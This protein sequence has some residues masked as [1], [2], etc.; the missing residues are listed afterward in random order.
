MR[1][2]VFTEKGK[3]ELLD[4]D[5]SDK[6]YAHTGDTI[7]TLVSTGTELARFSRDIE[8]PHEPGYAAVFKSEQDG[9]TYFCMGKHQER[10]FKGLNEVIPLPSGLEPEIALFARILAIPM[11]IAG[12][13][14]ARPPEPCIIV[15][16]G[17][18]GSILKEYF[19]YLGYT[20]FLYRS[21]GDFKALTVPL[22]IDCTGDDTVLSRLCDSVSSHGEIILSGVPWKYQS[23]VELHKVMKDIFYKDIVIKS[24]WEWS[25]TIDTAMQNFKDSLDL[26]NTGHIDVNGMYDRAKPEECQEVYMKHLNRATTALTTIFDWRK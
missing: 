11:Y 10:Q 26:L 8:F 18:L 3:A 17:L 7:F 23:N 14:F 12:I 13:A 20:V 19:N 6:M 16:K 25:G 15:G 24:G 5:I 1:R 22:A 9:N 2:I 21:G 4:I